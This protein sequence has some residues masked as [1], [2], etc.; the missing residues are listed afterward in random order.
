MDPSQRTEDST[1]S[2]S[3]RSPDGKDAIKAKD[4][5]QVKESIQLKGSTQVKWDETV[6]RAEA[7]RTSGE[8]REDTRHRSHSRGPARDAVSV[9]SHSRSSSRHS[10][11]LYAGSQRNNH[12]EFGA[13]SGTDIWRPRDTWKASEEGSFPRSRSEHEPS[14]RHHRE[15]PSHRNDRRGLPYDYGQPS[16]QGLDYGAPE[17]AGE[18]AHRE[19][20]SRHDRYN[21]HHH[22]RSHGHSYR[23][24]HEQE[25]GRSYANLNQTGAFS[26]NEDRPRPPPL[27]A[28]TYDGRVRGSQDQRLRRR[29]PSYGEYGQRPPHQGGQRN[30]ASQAPNAA[31]RH[32]NTG[33]EDA[34]PN[35]NE[36][37]RKVEDEI[38]VWE[39][40]HAN[41][42]GYDR[43]PGPRG[44]RNSRSQHGWAS[45][46][47]GRHA[48]GNNY[49]KGDSYPQE[50]PRAQAEEYRHLS[51][52]REPGDMPIKEEL[53]PLKRSGSPLAPM[54]ERV[55]GEPVT[56]RQRLESE[57]PREAQRTA[58]STES[59]WGAVPSLLAD[60]SA[61]L[62][63]EDIPP[64]P[65]SPPPRMA[66]A[67]SSSNGA[68][69]ALAAG[70]PMQIE[71][72][73]SAPVNR[74]PILPVN[75]AMPA[76]AQPAAALA[77]SQVSITV[78]PANNVGTDVAAAEKQT[79]TAVSPQELAPL[80]PPAWSPVLQPSPVVPPSQTGTVW[81][82]NSPMMQSPV[83]PAGTTQAEVP[84]RAA[85]PNPNF[86]FSLLDLRTPVANGDVMASDRSTFMRR[87]GDK[88]DP[89][90][91]LKAYNKKFV[92]IARLEDFIMPTGADKKEATLG[93]GTFGYV[94]HLFGK[95]H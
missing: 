94:Y 27:L 8:T 81:R 69:A 28:E 39:R 46:D 57:E 87:K 55:E 49:R 59:T 95:Q 50:K 40:P 20:R 17:E 44:D 58:D 38:P 77:P 90:D 29:S 15:D 72:P 32:I 82:Q 47:R 76:E 7:S 14:N 78:I 3:H 84:S 24:D 66:D 83:I 85:T 5:T 19:H 22:G 51:P 91:D 13:V 54:E 79:M 92:G 35:H 26:D 10:P 73:E 93:K 62:P 1:E 6:E 71:T 23:D 63:V 36:H 18:P 88:L 16:R 74:T 4:S 37:R 64:A 65:P 70:S 86:A 43:E 45:H 11:P 34:S 21:S 48:Y 33:W 89:A 9:R 30:P 41:Q 75:E 60:V 67:I 2:T 52:K 25:G 56:K 80:I 12:S 68:S 31:A 53:N 61:P 42:R